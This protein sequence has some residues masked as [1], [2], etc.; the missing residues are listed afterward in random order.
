[1]SPPAGIP[2]IA[3]DQLAPDLAEALRPRYERL[4]YLGEFFQYAAHQPEALAGF[5]EFTEACSRGLESNLV[6]LIA[7]TVA[8]RLGNTYE[9]NQHERLAV[10]RGH[11]RAWVAEV[12][13][14]DPDRAT[15]QPTEALVQRYVLGALSDVGHGTAAQVDA[16]AGAL[17]PAGAMA[18]LLLTARYLAHSL[19]VN[20][21]ELD[22]PVPSI[23][24][25]GFDV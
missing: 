15:L 22:P 3:F 17:G 4:G 12:E 11:G 18:V 7:L 14:L 6:Q 13:K 10:R 19:V 23:W 16:L 2:A 20:S 21:L 1:M 24:Q 5:V 8:G 9:T 25:D